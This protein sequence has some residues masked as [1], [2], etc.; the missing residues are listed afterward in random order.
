ML[1]LV[2]CDSVGLG[3]TYVRCRYSFVSYLVVCRW[4][5]V[6]IRSVW[7][8]VNVGQCC[9]HTVSTQT[10]REWKVYTLFLVD[11]ERMGDKCSV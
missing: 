11:P 9:S 8:S 10:H 6:R 5:M 1:E 3:C 7:F 2:L 4:Q